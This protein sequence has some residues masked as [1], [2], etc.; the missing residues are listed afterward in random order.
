MGPRPEQEDVVDI[1]ISG[2][3]SQVFAG[4]YDGHGGVE[5]ANYLKQNLRNRVL[6]KIKEVDSPHEAFEQ[7]FDEMD[8]AICQTYEAEGTGS[9]AAV[10]TIAGDALMCA[11]AGDCDGCL[12]KNGQAYELTTRHNCSNINEVQ[13]IR[14]AGGKVVTFGGGLRVGAELAVT[15]AF[16]DAVLKSSPDGRGLCACPDITLIRLDGTEEFAILG[17]DGLFEK[18]PSKQELINVTKRLLR[19]TRDVRRAAE[20]LVDL[21]VNH[22]NTRDNTSAVIIMLNQNGVNTSDRNIMGED[23]S[24]ASNHNP[25]N[26]RSRLVGYESQRAEEEF[27]R[28]SL[29]DARYQV[30]SMVSESNEED[31]EEGGDSEGSPAGKARDSSGTEQD[32]DQGYNTMSASSEDVSN[33]SASH[34]RNS[35]GKLT[36]DT[37]QL[38]AAN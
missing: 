7:S 19:Q 18:F 16:G 25:T 34:E 21:T 2:E 29:T 1:H 24:Y 11:N 31:M 14:N 9:C 22:R 38:V 26:L 35:S 33:L 30:S 4:V 32:V 8:K 17:S 13:R 27:R 5:V 28:T 6:A 3:K 37:G 36:M 20:E 15:R 10:L 12:C 23:R